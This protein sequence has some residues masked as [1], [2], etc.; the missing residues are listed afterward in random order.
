MRTISSR[1]RLDIDHLRRFY[2]H[3][4]FQEVKWNTKIL[5]LVSL[6]EFLYLLTEFFIG[7]YII[8]MLVINLPMKSPI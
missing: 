8:I 4:H 6:P 2:A 7:I 5:L 1:M 3:Q